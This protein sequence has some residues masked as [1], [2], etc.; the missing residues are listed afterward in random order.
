M[1]FFFQALPQQFRHAT[2]VF[3]NQDLHALAFMLT[4]GPEVLL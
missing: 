3:Y 4:P 1:S 2:L